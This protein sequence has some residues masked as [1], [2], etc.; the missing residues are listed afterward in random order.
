M[1][2]KDTIIALATPSGVGAIG[3]IR[4]SGEEAIRLTNEVF[5]PKD[6]TKQASHT[7]H[8]GRIEAHGNVYDEVLVSLFIGPHSYTKEHVIEISCHGS[9][10][11]Q[12]RIIQLFVEK[13][14]RLAQAGEFTQRAF[15]NGAFDLAQA[16]AVADVIAA[17]S[18]AA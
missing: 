2:F 4:L 3:V 1:N 8:Y 13:G 15:M 6:L 17:D 18:L 9:P 14:A 12:E 10:F 16:E 5:F 11:I 7:I